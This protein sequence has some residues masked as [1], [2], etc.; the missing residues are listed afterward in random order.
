MKTFTAEVKEGEDGEQYIVFPDE[1]MKE[2]GWVEGDTLDFAGQEDGS[3]LIKKIY[4]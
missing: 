3:V 1:L 4:T 2:L